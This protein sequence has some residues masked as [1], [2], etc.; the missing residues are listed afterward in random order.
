MMTMAR[1]DMPWLVRSSGRILGP[2]S[3]QKVG[4]LLRSRE[5]SMLD[6]ASAPGRRYQ[7]LQYLEEFRDVIDA[8][9]KQTLSERTE[10]SWSQ[11]TNLTQTLTDVDGAT[12]TEEIHDSGFGGAGSAREIVVTDVDEV[13]TGAPTPTGQGRYQ[14]QHGQ[15]TAIQRQV[16]KT[17]RG[18][19]LLTGVVLLLAVGF[20]LRKR[21]GVVIDPRPS[22][23]NYKQNVMN[24]IQVGHYAEALRELK[25]AISDPA[26]AGDMGI[27]Y[28]SLLVQVEGQT[29]LGRRLFNAVLSARRPEAKQAYAGLGVADLIDGQVDQAADSLE[30]AIALDADYVPAILNLA[31]VYLKRGNFDKA[32]ELATR[33]RR[34]NPNQGEALLTMAEAQLYLYKAKAAPAELDA[35][36]RALK[37][38]RQHHWD[39]SSELGF[40]DVYF[41]QLRRDPGLDDRLREY[42]DRDPQL[43]ADHR[44]NV[45]IYRGR[46]QWSVLAR[47]C[48]QSADQMAPTARAAAF[49][50]SCYAHEA[51]WDSARTAIERAVHQDPKDPLIQAWYSYILRE[52]GDADQAS[53]VLGRATEFD[54]R[55]EFVLPALMQARFCQLARIN[56]CARSWWQKLFERDLEMLPAIGGLASLHAANG[57]K[58]EAAPLVAKGL[59]I[60]PDYIPLLE[61]RQKAEADG[62][63]GVN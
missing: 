9:R 62:A 31:N 23:A 8:L 44:H 12:L 53:V 56:D 11:Q 18:L 41:D 52:S 26:Q 30:R 38:H 54:R 39:Y 6:E 34:L 27:Y 7:T 35:I 59:K 60:S 47:L 58:A 43:T 42:L 5:I 13:S 29:S 24:L 1:N 40:Y 63:S 51:R 55:G 28:G 50:A 16:E 36:S 46:Y 19:W 33:A 37:E 49:K 10:A 3:T 48:E 20:I 61:L 14:A 32:R 17:T 45:F 2:H 25:G 21:L 4:E 22:G 57:S 15:N